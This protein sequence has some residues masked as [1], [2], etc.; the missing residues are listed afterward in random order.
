MRYLK[1]AALAAIFTISACSQVK[2]TADSL[3]ANPVPADF[4]T[5]DAA[6]FFD[7]TSYA[8]ASSSG[9]A[10]SPDGSKVLVASDE[11]GIFNLYAVDMFRCRLRS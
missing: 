1:L 9:Y 4:T 10:F 2:D 11:T 3:A 5:Y 6:A 8:M 7:T